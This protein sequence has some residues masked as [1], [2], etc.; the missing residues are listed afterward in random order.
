MGF[1]TKI[2]NR[3]VKGAELVVTG[4]VTIFFSKFIGWFAPVALCI[5][6]LYRWLIRK[7]Y[8]DGMVSLAVGVIL[9]FL[10]KGPLSFL[11]WLPYTAGAI[12]LVYGAF[13]M[14]LPGRS[15]DD[16]GTTT[17]KPKDSPHI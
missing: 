12:L 4:G 5:Y 11:L 13:L 6:G 15:K 8:T 16:D 9:L 7:S 2:R 14:V 10:L 17:V 3:R 1:L